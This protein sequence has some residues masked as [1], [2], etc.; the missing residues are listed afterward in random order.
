MTEY[1]FLNIQSIENPQHDLTTLTSTWFS[2]ENQ[3]IPKSHKEKIAFKRQKPRAGPG[4]SA[5]C[6]WPA[7][8]RTDA[9][10]I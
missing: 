7:G 9:M 2:Y 10:E 8:E 6:W 3:N 5:S 4:S 1:I